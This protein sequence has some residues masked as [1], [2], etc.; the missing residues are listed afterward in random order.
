MAQLFTPYTL[1]GTTFHNRAWVAPM[2][3]YSA[4][5]GVVNDWHLIHYGALANGGYGL[6]VAEATAV[7]PQAR[8]TPGDAGLWNDEQVEAWS[9]VTR[10]IRERGSRSGVQ[11]AHAGRKA[12]TYSPVEAALG[13]ETSHGTI[14]EADGGWVTVAPTSHSFPGY[15]EPHA[16]SAEEIAATIADFAAAARR[17]DAAGF[18]VVE[19][20]GAHG[21][22]M[23]QF[24][25]ALSNDRTDEY[26]G[27][28]A[29]RA[30]FMLEVTAAV[31]EVWPAHKPLFMR[32]S[33]TDWLEGG[34][35]VADTATVSGWLRDLGVD[36]ISVS[37]A[38]LLPAPIPVGPGYQVPLSREVRSLSGV[39]T[40]VAGLITDALQAEQ[41]LVDQAA[42]AVLVGRLAL[43]EPSWPIRAARELGVAADDPAA[44]WQ[45]QYVRARL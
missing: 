37:S 35:T 41:I 4:V 19:L 33:A 39:P 43:R 34:V 30:R 17:A 20:H 29:G 21:Y 6:I 9:R 13:A 3:Q 38:A 16:L 5:D 10:A 36:L 22:L 24:L 23:H 40:A 14:P 44:H 42:D 12:A 7:S 11:I 8:I 31:R 18:D 27:D 26:G 45:P 25:S 2:C 28:L 15:A 1:S 32:L